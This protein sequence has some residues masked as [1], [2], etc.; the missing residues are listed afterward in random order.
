MKSNLWHL[1][2]KSSI[3]PII[4]I[5]FVFILHL[6]QKKSIFEFNFVSLAQT[7]P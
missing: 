4:D 5:F 1:R 7:V 3:K 2:D 6:I